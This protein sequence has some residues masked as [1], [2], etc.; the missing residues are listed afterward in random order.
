MHSHT[1]LLKVY[2]NSYLSGRLPRTR[3]QFSHACLLTRSKKSPKKENDQVIKVL[4]IGCRVILLLD[5]Q[6]GYRPV[7]SVTRDHSTEAS[8]EC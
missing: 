2:L 3:P 6:S 8:A 5:G 7:V 4:D 1:F